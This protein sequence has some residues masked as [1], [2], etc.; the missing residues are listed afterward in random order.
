VTSAVVFGYGG[1]GHA[2]LAAVLR[3]G[4]NVAQ[5][6][7]HA[8][9]PD[10]NCWWP[11]LT[12][13]TRE[14]N[15]PVTLDADL[16]DDS[17]AGPGARLQAI[18]PDFIFSFYFRHL[19]GERLLAHA[20][21]GAYNLHGSLLPLFRGRAPI[22]W[23]LVHGALR[24]GLT[25]HRMV[26]KADAGDIAAQ[27]AI[28][29]HAD[30]DAYGLT[31]QL[32]ELAPGFLDRALAGLLSD[33]AVERTQD[34][35]QATVF[36][37]RTPADGRLDWA[38]PARAVHNLVRAVAPPWPGAFTDHGG[39][40]LIVARTRVVAET[41]RLGEPGAVIAPDTVAC[42]QGAIAILSAFR[43]S[44][45]VRLVTGDRCATS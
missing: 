22:N 36:G 8:D 42:G 19:L 45:A 10:E 1:F 25:L 31:L 33:R 28:D 40:K 3:A 43:A 4:I 38:K 44:G 2:G 17:P 39:E 37:R 30:Q 20:Q 32:L 35:A 34:H 15:L 41:G 16:K 7:S 11:S 14:R 5:V 9:S 13:L 21:R 27:E 23:Q 26:R 18:R 12:A 29:V 6:F 24:S